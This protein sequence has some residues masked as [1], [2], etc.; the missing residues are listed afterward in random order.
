MAIVV[1][2]AALVLLGVCA[3]T[4]DIGHA[5]VEKS[6]M[7]RRADFSALAGGAGENLPKVAAGSV[8]VQGP[9]SWTKPKVDDP[10]IVDAVAYLNRNLPTG[11]DVSPT[12]VTTAGELLNCRLGDGEA[13]Y[14]VWN[15]PDSNGFRSFTANPNQLSVISQPRQVD[16]GFASVLGFDSVNV[17]GQATVEIKTPLM[18]TLPFYAFAPCDYGQQTFSQP[19][20]GHAATNVNLADAGN[21]STYTSFVT[22]TSLETSPAS[23]PPAIA[24]NPSPSTNVP[25]VINGTNLNT[26]TKIGF[27]QSGESTPP[28]PTY[29]D[30]GVTPAAWTVTGTTKIN[31]ASVPAN[32]I[33]TQG[34]WFVRV[35][36]Q[37]SANGA[38]ASQKAWTPIVDNQDNLVALPLAV[39]NATLSCEEGPSEGNFGTL[40]LDRETSPNAGGEPGEIARNIALGL[41]HGLAPFPTARLAPPDYVCSDGVNDAHEWPYDGTNCVGTKPGLPSE[42]AEKGFVTGV[43][44]EYAGLLTNV[45]DGTGC[46]ED[47]KPATTVLLGKEIN[48][49]VLSCFFTNDDVTVGDVSARTYSGDVVI[50]QTIYKSSRFVLIPVLGR[51]P[52][53]GSCENYQI[54]DFRPGF[55]GE[56]PDATTRLTNDVSPDNGLTLT[57]SNGNPSLQA[58]K[59]IFLNPK[60]LPDPPLDPNGNYI[61][62]VGAGK[63]SLLLVD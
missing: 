6:G 49:D 45:D 8:C 42:A 21:S 4:V 53:C 15:E 51:Q 12:Q 58:V 46:A 38:G 50:S 32:V 11:P 34:T 24:H 18:K 26:V 37:K 5:L 63:K 20:P 33:S 14:G 62:Y 57:S 16:F 17:G 52:D 43:S 7:Q 27:Y 35:F 36:G 44:G 54:V 29:V 25:L 61:P 39:G 60:A 31:L 47:G 19:A 30:I 9:Y 56:Q 2:I 23:D 22:A 3:L 48:N 10:A 41:E 55:I 13:G 40:S 1:A 28:A 59:V